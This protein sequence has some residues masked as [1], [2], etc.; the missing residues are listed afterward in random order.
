ML[1]RW[2]QVVEALNRIAGQAPMAGQLY[3]QGDQV[4]L[5]AT[6]LCF[7]HQKMKLFPKRY[8]PFRIAKEI[9]PV[10]FWLELLASWNIH[11]VFHTSLLS[12]YT[13]TI[14][15]GPNFSRLPPDLIDGEEE[16]EVEQLMAHRY[17]RQNKVL[18]YLVKWKGYPMSDNT[19][20]PVDQIHAP[21]LLKTYHRRNPLTSIKAMLI[22]GRTSTGQ[23]ADTRSD[24]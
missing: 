4:W 14:T 8:G 19:W 7:P 1:E 13:E 16:Y 3:K 23:T 10:A 6:H 12:P 15:H 18:Q 20:E 21:D 9:S 22:V 5:E 24:K 2:Q 17:H 11:N